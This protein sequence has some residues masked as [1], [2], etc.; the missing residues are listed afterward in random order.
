MVQAGPDSE[1]L[2][3]ALTRAVPMRRLGHPDE[4]APAVA[5]LAGED[6]RH[7]RLVAFMARILKDQSARLMQM[8]D[9]RPGAAGNGGI[10]ECHFVRDLVGKS[11]REAFDHLQMLRGAEQM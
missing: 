4:V 11:P 9:G 2:R 10:C 8:H 3:D 5:F 6:A 1:R 7:D